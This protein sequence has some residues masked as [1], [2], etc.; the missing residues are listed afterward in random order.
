ML[1]GPHLRLYSYTWGKGADLKNPRA[2]KT[3]RGGNDRIRLLTGRVFVDARLRAGAVLHRRRAGAGTRDARHSSRAGV[4]ARA[5][6]VS[7]VD[8]VLADAVA[9]LLTGQAV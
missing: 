7:V 4:A 9:F 6:V 5:A 2:W 3:G 1:G 8:N